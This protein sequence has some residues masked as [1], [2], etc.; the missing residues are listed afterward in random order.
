MPKVA[1]LITPDMVKSVAEVPSS[2][3]VIVLVAPKATGQAISAPSVPVVASV[4]LIFPARVNTPVPVIDD[5]VTA[6]HSNSN[7]V[8]EP[9]VLL[10]IAKIAPLL[11][12]K[13]PL[14]VKLADNV[15]VPTESLKL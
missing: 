1:P 3:T 6:P 2:A 14:T 4:T 5:P 8:G 11:T 15:V 13:D 12:V 10:P 9:I 7:E